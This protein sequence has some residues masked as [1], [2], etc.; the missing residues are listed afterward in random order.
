V[1][2]R[3]SMHE[4]AAARA[5]MLHEIGKMDSRL[6]FAAVIAMPVTND[7]SA[8]CCTSSSR[9]FKPPKIFLLMVNKNIEKL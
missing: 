5:E 7:P 9:S 2:Q 8:N 4:T 3:N 1:L 6:I